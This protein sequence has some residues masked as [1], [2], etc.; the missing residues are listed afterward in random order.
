MENTSIYTTPSK[1]GKAHLEVLR[2][3]MSKKQFKEYCKKY[4]CEYTAAGIKYSTKIVESKKRYSR[5]LK[6]QNS[7]FL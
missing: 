1:F 6:H 4:R 3:S 5:K 7:A 2:K